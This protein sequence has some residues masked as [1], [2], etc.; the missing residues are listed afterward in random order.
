RLFLRHV[1]ISVS[2][3][4]P[5]CIKRSVER[6]C[7]YMPGDHSRQFGDAPK[8]PIVFGMSF[9]G[10]WYDTATIELDHAEDAVSQVAEL[11]GKLRFVGLPKT[12]IRKVAIASRADVP[13]Q[14]VAQR[15]RTELCGQRNG[16]N[17]IAGR[18]ADLAAVHR[19]IAV[20]KDPSRQPQ[21]GGQEHGRPVD[22]MEAGDAL[23]DDMLARGGVRP[24]A[25]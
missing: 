22:G 4:A 23:P 17:G 15:I 5:D 19:H 3:E 21:A 7:P 25:R 16:V 18:L 13:Q 11:A 2:N 9:R 1:A 20:D 12:L 24:V 8:E 6:E 10:R 14:V